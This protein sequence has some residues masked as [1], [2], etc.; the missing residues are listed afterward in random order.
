VAR[1][2]GQLHE[3]FVDDLAGSIAEMTLHA[4]RS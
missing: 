2:I 3:S 1:T 4:E